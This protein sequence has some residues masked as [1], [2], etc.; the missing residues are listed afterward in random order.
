MA[1][2]G[3]DLSTEQLGVVRA[4]LRRVAP[5]RTVWAFGS[6]VQGTARRAS[7][8]DLALVGEPASLELIGD[9]RAAFSESDLP[10]KVDVVDLASADD[11]FRRIV[12]AGY[13]VITSEG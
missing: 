4:V 3:L 9:L 7:D 13:V 11:T 8:L 2:P 10:M 6:R 5:G 1:A 12:E